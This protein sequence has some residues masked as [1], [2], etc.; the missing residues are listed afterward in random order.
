[1]NTAKAIIIT[2]GDELLIGQI[3]DTNSAWIAQQLNIIGIDVVQRVAI[4]DEKKA[5][6]DSLQNALAIADI[7]LLTGGLG[8][9][10]DDIT[11]PVL[12]DFFGGKLIV[13]EQVLA[14][15]KA[16]F[17]K[18]N[19]PFIERN[20]KQAEVPDVCTVLHNPMG[21][22][23][24][25]LFAQ[26]GKIIVSMPGVPFEMKSIMESSV[27]SI[28][29]KKF[30]A[31]NE[32]FHSTILTFGEGE[33]FLAEKIRD[34]EEKL[35]AHIKLAYLPSPF[36][37]KLRLSAHGKNKNKLALEVNQYRDELIV[38][39]GK[40]VAAIEDLPLEKLIGKILIEKKLSLALAES[41]TGGNIGHRITEVE[42][43]SKYF[44]GNVVCYDTKI[45]TDL[46]GIPLAFIKTNG[47]VSEEVAK[48][49]AVAACKKLEASIGLGITGIFSESDY[50]DKSP[51]GTVFI[52]IA[53]AQN[54]IEIYKHLLHY[55]RI[56]NKETATQMAL[57]HLLAFVKEEK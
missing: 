39:L 55:N 31:G 20:A 6:I 34:I 14:H 23:P 47:V 27:L 53:N 28:L 54:K 15:V 38:R 3:I 18:R 2:I 21:T 48:A 35:P 1:M 41:C 26:N 9:T 33:S 11:K 42:G 4:A 44:K 12:C 17:E 25:M 10:A 49:M 57:Y 19:R 51:V 40:T 56:Q 29:N 46:L 36:A 22:A 5:I 50:E 43:A 13:N 8:P 45:K 16:M 37:V 32:I 7:V 24:G 52:A 30:N